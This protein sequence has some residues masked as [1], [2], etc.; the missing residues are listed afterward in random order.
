MS[1]TINTDQKKKKK[2]VF[3]EGQRVTADGYEGEGTVR[4][5]GKEAG[6]GKSRVGVE[7]DA[8]VGKNRGTVKVRGCG[9]SHVYRAESVDV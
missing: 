7:M 6:G 4:F 3:E 1:S 9:R 5:V 8:P 2:V